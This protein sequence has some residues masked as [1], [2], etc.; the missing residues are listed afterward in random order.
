M[1]SANDQM[2][3][4]TSETEY[5]QLYHVKGTHTSPIKVPVT[6]NGTVHTFKLDTGAVVLKETA[7]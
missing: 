1:T 2:L 3:E 6:I 4:D 5:L 7:S